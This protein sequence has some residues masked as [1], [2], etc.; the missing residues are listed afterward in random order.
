MSLVKS[1]TAPRYRPST[2][3]PSAPTLS[4]LH[5]TIRPFVSMV[6]ARMQV[7][8]VSS[9]RNLLRSQSR[10]KYRAWSCRL[11][12]KKALPSLTACLD[13]P[14]CL[15]YLTRA[16]YYPRSFHGKNFGG[17]APLKV[18]SPLTSDFSLLFFFIVDD[19]HERLSCPA[20][21]GPQRSRGGEKGGADKRSRARQYAR[22]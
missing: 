1:R 14:S 18:S 12:K 21:S 22:D 16:R 10:A 2:L 5:G 17:W 13:S 9:Q 7:R 4:K 8:K 6:L 15:I 19:R 11:K 20:R 3:P